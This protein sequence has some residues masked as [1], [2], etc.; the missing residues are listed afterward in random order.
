[1]GKSH[2]LGVDFGTSNS[3]AGF[4]D[5]GAVRLIEVEPGQTT[6]PTAFFFDYDSRETLIGSAANRA[7]LDGAEGRYMRALKRVLGTGLMHEPRQILNEQVTFVEIIARFLRRIKQRAE[8]ETGLTFERVLSG[9]PVRFHSDN[10]GRDAQAEVDLR[11]CYLAAGF[12]AVDF[13]SEPEAAAIATRRKGGGRALGLVVD[14][15]GGTSDFSLFE[16]ASGGKV[17]VIANQGVTIGGTDFDRLLSLDHVMELLGKGASLRREF[18]PGLLTAPNRVFTDLAT[19]EKIPFQYGAKALRSVQ[20]MAKFAQEPEKFD[21]LAHVVE[22]ELGHDLAFAVE[23]AKIAI[24]QQAEG[25]VRVDIGFLEPQ[26]AAW[27]D[28][29]Q[30]HASLQEAIGQVTVC[31]LETLKGAGVAPHRVDHVVFVGGSSLLTAVSAAI[32]AVFPQAELVFS[33]VFTAVTDGLALAA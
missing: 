13:L 21:R 16:V 19:W 20:E 14:I 30:M 17:N 15:G 28:R 26:L 31:A 3:A 7:L 11:A 5:Q 4:V 2:R 27:F 1:M 10:A 22:Y 12:K 18:G 29:A 9:R 33:E 25:S 23:H 8:Q 6:L 32:G 24:N